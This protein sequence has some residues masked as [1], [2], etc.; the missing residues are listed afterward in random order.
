MHGNPAVFIPHSLLE[1]SFSSLR[2]SGISIWKRM[3]VDAD[4][5]DGIL[6]I[7]SAY[8]EIE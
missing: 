4:D 7:H 5:D 6:I 3:L 8:N 2:G 1:I